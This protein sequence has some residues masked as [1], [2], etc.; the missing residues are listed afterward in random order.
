VTEQVPDWLRPV[1]PQSVRL[2]GGPLQLLDRIDLAQRRFVPAA[3]VVAVVRKYLRDRGGQMAALV[4]YFSFFSVFP[5]LLV[6]TAVLGFVLDDDPGLQQRIVDSAFADVPMVGMQIEHDIGSLT[7]SA[8]AVVTG[9]LIATWGGLRVVD[10]AQIAFHDVWDVPREERPWF[11]HRRLRGVRLLGVIGLF[12]AGSAIISPVAA[13]LVELPLVGA[14]LLTVASLAVNV[15]VFLLGFR[16]LSPRSARW[17]D[18][19]AGSIVAG[20]GWLVLRT[21][22]ARYLS[23]VITTASA[24]YRDFAG[25]IGLLTFFWLVGQLV[26]VAAEVNVVHARRLWPRALRDGHLP[27]AE[28]DLRVASLRQN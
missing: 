12:V 27:P 19:L 13:V 10:T 3:F 23:Q 15:A 18:L 26:I 28:G 9:L 5:L 8:V 11:L 2:D 16:L 6:A 20:V 7:G 17:R 1:A 21:I 22:G 25:V 24:T 4:S 14:V